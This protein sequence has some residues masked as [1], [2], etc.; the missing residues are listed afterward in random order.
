MTSY[1]SRPCSR[2]YVDEKFRDF[3]G[4]DKNYEKNVV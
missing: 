3:V 4:E 2:T 1:V